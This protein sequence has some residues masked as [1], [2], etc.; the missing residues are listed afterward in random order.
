MITIRV[1]SDVPDLRQPEPWRRIVGCFQRFRGNPHLSFVHYSAQS[2]HLHSIAETEGTQALSRGMQTFS[3]M[4]GKTIN[5]CFRR[6]GPVFAGRYHAHE[7]KTPTEI[8]NAIEYVL[9]NRRKHAA[10]AGCTMPAGWVDDCSTAVTFDGWRR[11]V[12]VP[13]RGDDFGTSPPRTWLLREGW[14]F[15]GPLDL[16][17]I[18]GRARPR[19]A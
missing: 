19:A 2:D 4:L 3:G 9:L 13:Q 12:V 18:P 10:D 15:A 17:T 1:R 11:I 8:R 7:L 16:E 6:R 14:R 5:R